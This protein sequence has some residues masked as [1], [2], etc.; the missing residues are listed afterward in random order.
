MHSSFTRSEAYSNVAVSVFSAFDHLFT[1]P[2][3]AVRELGIRRDDLTLSREIHA[4]IGEKALRLIERICEPTAILFRQVATPNYETLHFLEVAKQLRLKPIILEYTHDKFVSA[5]NSYKRALGKVP[6]FQHTGSDGRDM[7]HYK[8]HVDFNAYTGK[9]LREVCCISE[10]TLVDWHHDQ[11]QRVTQIPIEELCF[12]ASDIFTHWGG[13]AKEYYIPLMS[14]F[15]RDAI[16]F[17]NY[18]LSRHLSPFMHDIVI[19]SFETV[20]SRYALRPLIVRLLPQEQE[21][22]LF[23]NSYPKDVLELL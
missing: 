20:E 21:H 23:W 18:E 6:V 22:R 5:G 3:T 16:M 9:P 17:E 2:Q 15:I 7:V 11:L 13:A 10:Q 4:H 8:T 19:P 14:L 12:D 1:E